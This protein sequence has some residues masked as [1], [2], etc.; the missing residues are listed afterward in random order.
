VLVLY[1]LSPTWH[2]CNSY[3]IKIV[4]W[5]C[6]NIIYR[7]HNMALWAWSLELDSCKRY[8]NLILHQ[9][10]CN[11]IIMRTFSS[12]FSTFF[13]TINIAIF[14]VYLFP[15]SDSIFAGLAAQFQSRTS[16]WFHLFLWIF[17]LF[18]FLKIVRLSN[19]I[20]PRVKKKIYVNNFFVKIVKRAMKCKTWGVKIERLKLRGQNRTI[21]KSGGPKLQFNHFYVIIYI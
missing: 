1:Y 12:I 11:E 8:V 7:F 20:K 13:V 3:A 21:K 10:N 19:I 17:L 2:A 15:M 16:N 5:F 9:E 14:P 18:F 4:G 6:C